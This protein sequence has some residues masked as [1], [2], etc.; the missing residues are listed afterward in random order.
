VE[1]VAPARAARDARESRGPVRGGDAGETDA[2]ED[3]L[4]KA[5]EECSEDDM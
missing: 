1:R 5:E 4:E 2:V 3:E